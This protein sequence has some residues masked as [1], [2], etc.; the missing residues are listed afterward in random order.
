MHAAVCGGV[1]RICT[2]QSALTIDNART[3]WPK[4]RLGCPCVPQV[5]NRHGGTSVRD[6]AM[7]CWSHTAPL[8][9]LPHGTP[10]EAELA[11]KGLRSVRATISLAQEVGKG[12]G[13]GEVLF[14]S[15]PR[16]EQATTSGT[17]VCGRPEPGCAHTRWCPHKPGHP[18][19]Q[20]L[21]ANACVRSSQRPIR[22]SCFS[23]CPCVQRPCYPPDWDRGDPLPWRAVW[24]VSSAL[25]KANVSAKPA[26]GL[27]C[28]MAQSPCPRLSSRYC[29][30]KRSCWPQLGERQSF[31]LRLSLKDVFSPSLSWLWSCLLQ[32]SWQP[33]SRRPSCR[34]PCA[35]LSM[36]CA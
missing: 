16:R 12:V 34:Q 10:Q 24:P 5:K 6:V 36:M 31:L 30:W 14:G 9:N 33:A 3:L 2:S 35:R 32:P 28:S 17:V 26:S 29:A 1:A 25:E 20:G 19:T 21:V 13:P 22:S 27:A 15:V 18:D 23:H 8:R 4:R 7:T 11:G